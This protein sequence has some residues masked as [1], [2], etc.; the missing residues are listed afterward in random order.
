MQVIEN[1]TSIKEPNNEFKSYEVIIVSNVSK[2][3][4]GYL[5]NKT[6]Y[7][8]LEYEEYKLNAL[9]EKDIKIDDLQNKLNEANG[10]INN[11]NQ[12]VNSLIEMVITTTLP[13][14]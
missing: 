7:N 6:I 8:P 14:T 9:K 4:N 2:T 12:L 1:C 5:F 13:T 3:E 11:Q 10:T